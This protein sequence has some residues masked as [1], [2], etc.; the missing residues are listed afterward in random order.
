[1]LLFNCLA[2][3]AFV[4]HSPETEM[5]HGV[6]GVQNADWISHPPDWLPVPECELWCGC[7]CTHLHG[8]P[9]SQLLPALHPASVGLGHNCLL[10]CCVPNSSDTALSKK[11]EGGIE[12]LHLTVKEK[13]ASQVWVI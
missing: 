7:Q 1:M 13:H 2:A 6:A 3:V 5:K 12:Q 10:R 8:E 9:V 4:P 11:E